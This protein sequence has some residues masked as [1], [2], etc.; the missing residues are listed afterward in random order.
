MF[1]SGDKMMMVS[2]MVACIVVWTLPQSSCRIRRC[3]SVASVV[4]DAAYDR[5]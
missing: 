5:K 4:G 2:A 1:V 3:V